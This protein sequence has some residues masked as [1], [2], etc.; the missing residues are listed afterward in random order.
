MGFEP[1]IFHLKGEY[2][3]A[4]LRIFPQKNKIKYLNLFQLLNNNIFNA[5]FSNKLPLSVGL[6]L[7]PVLFVGMEWLWIGEEWIRVEKNGI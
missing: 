1:F 5:I 2:F 6:A 3:I 4:Q 7:G